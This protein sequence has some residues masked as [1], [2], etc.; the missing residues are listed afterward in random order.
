MADTNHIPDRI[1]KL[2]DEEFQI[3][4][5]FVQGQ[6][7]SI[8]SEN[9]KLE[10]TDTSIRLSDRAGK[11]I[12]ISKQ[13]NQWQRKVLITNNSVYRQSIVAALQAAGCIDR[14]KSSHPEFTEHHFYQLPEYY[15]LNY[16]ETIELWKV[17]WNNKRYQLNLPKPPIDVLTFTKGNWY[18]VRDLQPKQGN[19]IIRT[20]RGEISV[21]PDEYVVWIDAIEVPLAS[22][23]VNL[24]SLTLPTSSVITGTEEQPE[25]PQQFEEID[26]ESYLNTFNTEDAE[27]IDRIEGIYN[28]GELLSGNQ[29][30]EDVLPV[31]PVANPVASLPLIPVAI[32]PAPIQVAPVEPVASPEPP[33]L[34]PT[35]TLP[36]LSISERQAALREKAMQV[37]AAYL[38]DGDL[39]TQTEVLK[40]AQ[41]QEMNRKVV[42]TQRGC[43][44]WAIDQIAKLKSV[45][46]Q[47]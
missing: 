35:P 15:K 3:M 26:L 31:T 40:N 21:E 7:H 17:W 30:L 33:V 18:L 42:K 27:D 10:Y 14:Q 32:E 38:Q 9:L 24:P 45:D 44:R 12:G 47:F 46:R 28:I 6:K 43:P 37:L 1:L 5:Y 41:G 4:G 25:S 34:T 36:L 39:V 11:L 16:T 13:V 23:S 20:E 19:F 29:I 22:K 8:S 2:T